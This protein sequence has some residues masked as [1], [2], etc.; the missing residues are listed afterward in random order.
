[1]PE[2]DLSGLADLRAAFAKGPQA[3][4]N[5]LAFATEQA[6][7]DIMGD[8]DGID[9][10]SAASV[11]AQLD[12]IKGGEI[13]LR[14]N[15]YGGDVLEGVAIHNA[16]VAHPARIVAEIIG[17]AASAASWIAMAADEVLIWE[18]AMMMIHNSWQLLAGNKDMFGEAIEVLGKIDEAMA[19][20]YVRRTGLAD[21][22]I[23]AMMDAETWLTAE[24]AVA[25]GFADRMLAIG[26][27]SVAMQTFNASG[28]WIKPGGTKPRPASRV[29]SPEVLAG[30]RG[31]AAAMAPKGE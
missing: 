10:I 29:I 8:I 4:S 15:S 21:A 24:E 7:L 16:L 22:E 3:R 27:G 26:A 9:G 13:R 5:R 12:A 17:V 23:R 28:E 25:K 11:V 30:L 2:I 31:L 19:A 20:S 1:M 14:I 18:G 6:R